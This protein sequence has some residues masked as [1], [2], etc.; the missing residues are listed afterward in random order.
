MKRY[1]ALLL[2]GVMVNTLSMAQK[3]DPKFELY[4]LAGQSNMA[5]R[6]YITGD[7]K[8][9]GD[10]M[11]Y[12]LTK[13][14]KWVIAKH[15]VHFDKSSAGVGPGLTFGMAMAKA[16]PK[17]RIGLIPTAVG[18]TP[19]EHWQPG[20]YD[21]PTKTHPYDEATERIK[22]AM[23]YG[24]IKGIIWH[25]GESDSKPE[26]AAV[27]LVKLK[28]LIARLRTL[29]NNPDLPFIV[30]EL[31]RYRPE[32]ANINNELLKLPAMVPHTAVATSEGLVHRGDTLHFD[33]P[34]ADELGRR[35]AKK[36]LEVQ[37]KVK[38]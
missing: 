35:Y 18:G 20:A 19:I 8:T 3:P 38:K 12:M 9:E 21:P 37:K 4:I 22:F 14:N 36:M 27:Y 31:G 11:V 25:Q 23:Q 7:Y 29:V 15:P 26:Q 6:G 32:F 2:L 24:V 5:G 10:T 33:S 1:F 30:G 34:S 17:V 16:H 28:E 13:D